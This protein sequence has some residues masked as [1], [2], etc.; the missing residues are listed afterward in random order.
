[1][2]SPLEPFSKHDFDHL[3]KSGPPKNEVYLVIRKLLEGK[4]VQ[5]LEDASGRATADK[6]IKVKHIKLSIAK[7][8]S[9]YF[10]NK[11]R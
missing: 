8:G 7:V 6:V 3:W 4:V 11:D 1:M 2:P 10:V 9:L 5:L